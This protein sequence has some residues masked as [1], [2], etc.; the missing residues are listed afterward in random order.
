MLGWVK[1]FI[2]YVQGIG[3]CLRC[4]DKWNWKS[5]HVTQ[6]SIINGCFPLCSPCWRAAG[7]DQ[8]ERYYG[9][10]MR[11]WRRGGSFYSQEDENSIIAAALKEKGFSA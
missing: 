4:G 2:G 5:F 1:N 7:P 8:I 3:G 9:E 10:L 6:Y 11:M